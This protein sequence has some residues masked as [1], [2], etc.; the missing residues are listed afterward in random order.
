MSVES[1]RLQAVRRGRILE[2]LTVGWNSV[3]ALVAIGAGMVAGSV[4]LVGFGFDSVVETLSGAALLWRL[5][6]DGIEKR[7]KSEALALKL[8]GWSFVLLALYVA[9]D[10]V[11]SLLARE[12]PDA[13]AL[14]VGIAAVSIV[15]MP[16]LAHAKRRVASEIESDAL[17]ADSRQTDICAYLSAILLVGLALNWAFGWWWADPLAALVMVP[18]IGWEGVQTLRG[19]SCCSCHEK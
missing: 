9:F 7:E 3:E 2:Y 4:A 6:Q 17:H 1:I 11:R 19:E 15:V 12:A 5:H 14:G 13:S 10:A 16:L 18:I 8:V